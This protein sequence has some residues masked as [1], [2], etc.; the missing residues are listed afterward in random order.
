MI[1]AQGSNN[2]TGLLISLDG[3]IVSPTTTI[4]HQET[5]QLKEIS[6]AIPL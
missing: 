4:V 2:H 6:T 3:H 1:P 5:S